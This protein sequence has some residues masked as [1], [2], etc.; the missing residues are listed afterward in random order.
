M[1]MKT[2]KRLLSVLVLSMLMVLAIGMVSAAYANESGNDGSVQWTFLDGTKTL[3]IEGSG[4][5]RKENTYRKYQTDVRSLIIRDSIS[6]INPGAFRDFTALEKVEI[7]SANI[8]VW[9]DAFRN[10]QNLVN[11]S[12]PAT[13]DMNIVYGIESDDDNELPFWGCNIKDIRIFIT[14]VAES[15]ILDTEI[16]KKCNL[17]GL[18]I[19]PFGRSLPDS[20][21]VDD[22][23]PFNED[24]ELRDPVDFGYHVPCFAAKRYT[25]K[26]I[27]AKPLVKLHEDSYN[28]KLVE[29]IDYTLTYSN[30]KN[31]GIATC[32]ITGIEPFY[33]S[34]TVHFAI[35]PKGTSI[36][37]VVPAKKAF[38]VKWLK[39]S[40]KMSKK[41]ITGYVVEWSRY[42]NFSDPVKRKTVKG[43][44]K[45][46]LKIKNLKAKK[47]YYVRVRT[48]Y[49]TTNDT[50]YSSWSPAKSVKTK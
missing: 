40:K 13:A 8:L 41:R 11:F 44:K 31:V 7:T 28:N 34:R 17:Y 39:Q 46:S 45:T 27:K 48:Y 38:T 35:Y 43:Y 16:A 47:K 3:I 20:I 37:K 2:M 21:F 50:F 1:D 30:N 29:G 19:E 33:G 22:M 6:D 10:C 15:E 26:A 5:L 36:T 25:G 18:Y 4:D 49:K 14:G 12:I 32:K 24:N 9:S 23:D 42:K